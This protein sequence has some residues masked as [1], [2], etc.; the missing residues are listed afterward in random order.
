MVR[1]WCA[2]RVYVKGGVRSPRNHGLRIILNEKE[3]TV[4]QIRMS[5]RMPRVPELQ[6]TSFSLGRA[7]GTRSSA[8]GM[9]WGKRWRNDCGA[10]DNEVSALTM[11]PSSGLRDRVQRAQGYQ[12]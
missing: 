12:P 3:S 6:S 11:H 9:K 2:L 8:L 4:I 5:L 7:D 1:I 10:G